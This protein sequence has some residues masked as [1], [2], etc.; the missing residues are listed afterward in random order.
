MKG[1]MNFMSETKK[2]VIGIQKGEEPLDVDVKVRITKT[3]N[4]NLVEYAKEH[5]ITRADAIRKGIDELLK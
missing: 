4:R 3:V 1:V 5:N 2:R